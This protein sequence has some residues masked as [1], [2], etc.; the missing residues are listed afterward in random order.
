[1]LAKC[2]CEGSLKNVI[3]VR[4][5]EMISP[6]ILSRNRPD[7]SFHAEVPSHEALLAAWAG[8]HRFL[9]TAGFADLV[10]LKTDVEIKINHNETVAMRCIFPFLM[11][12]KENVLHN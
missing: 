10:A 7:E 4:N 8:Q 6:L 9:F 1:M 3:T 5:T 11:L 12:E 2:A